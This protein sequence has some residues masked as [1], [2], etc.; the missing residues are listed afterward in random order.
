MITDACCISFCR[1]LT[2]RDS[3][4]PWRM[5]RKVVWNL[6]E[7]KPSEEP[8]SMNLVFSVS[9]LRGGN[10]KHAYLTFQH[11]HL[12]AD[13]NNEIVSPMSLQILPNRSC[14][15]C[16]ISWIRNGARNNHKARQSDIFL[17]HI[18]IFWWMK[19]QTQLSHRALNNTNVCS[20]Q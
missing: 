2:W 12:I 4:W 8:R 1:S 7:I 20:A 17:W 10:H 15:G 6:F 16:C 9:S 19:A 11:R 5:S 14:Y 3:S 13:K 18:L